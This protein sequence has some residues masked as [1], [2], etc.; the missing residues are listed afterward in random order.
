VLGIALLMPPFQAADELA[1]FERA[2]QLSLGVLVATRTPDGASGGRIDRAV[3]AAGVLFDGIKFHV[4]HKVTRPMLD[5]ANA[6]D[7]ARDGRGDVPFPNTAI[8]PP[9]LYATGALGVGLGRLTHLSVPHTLILSRVLTGFASVAIAAFAIARAG[10]AASFLFSMLCLPMSLALFASASQD[11]PMIALSAFALA[12]LRSA[13]RDGARALGLASLALALILMA[14]PP[15]LPLALLLLLLPRPV[16]RR[17]GIACAGVVAAALCWSAT[18]GHWSQM[19][20]SAAQ[21]A[22]QAHA[23]LAHPLL[24]PRALVGTLAG[25]VHEGLPW[26]RQFIGVLGWLDTTLPPPYLLLAGLA[27]LLA[28]LLSC[29]EHAPRLSLARR[30][31]LLL[32]IAAAALAILFFQYLSWT[33]VG[34]AYIDGVQGRYFLPLAAILPLALPRLPVPP[35]IRRGGG[36]LICLF[37]ALSIALTLRAIVSRYYLS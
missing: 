10:A 9:F 7:W 13:T 32:C 23:V 16:P 37:P 15:Y 25:Q 21:I 8:Y 27:L 6:I 14:R 22:R 17:R 2:D 34:A 19:P 29:P 30:V 24:F 5:A 26:G 4:E 18:A 35:A 31:I 28:L 11:G 12:A 3:P 20:G 1:Q 36:V 33:P